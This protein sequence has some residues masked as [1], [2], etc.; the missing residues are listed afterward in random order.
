MGNLLS[1]VVDGGVHVYEELKD[2]VLIP[3]LSLGLGRCGEDSAVGRR[4]FA[5]QAPKEVNHGTAQGPARGV[6]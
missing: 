4:L 5:E 2:L 1:K 3:C 6:K